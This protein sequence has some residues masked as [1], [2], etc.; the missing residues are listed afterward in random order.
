MFRMGRTMS[1]GQRPWPDVQQRFLDA[2]AHSAH[3]AEPLYAIAMHYYEKKSWGLTYL[4][5]KR[6]ADLPFP[7][8]AS[9]FVDRDVYRYKLLDLVGTA[10][11]YVGELEAGEAALTKA[12]ASLGEHEGAL[13][14]RFTKNLAF[15]LDRAKRLRG[16]R[17]GA[18]R[19]AVGFCA[20]GGQALSALASCSVA[21]ARR[22]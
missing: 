6:G 19:A 1:L 13:K 14:E 3:R 8:K 18:A 12:I 2:Y 20:R 21:P 9:L 11:F 10:A 15:Y 7:E 4:F 17:R 22:A 5:A 16:A